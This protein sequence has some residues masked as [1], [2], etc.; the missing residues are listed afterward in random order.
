MLSTT[1]AQICTHRRL[2]LTRR[3]PFT[4]PWML[5]IS[6]TVLL[7]TRESMSPSST[8]TL[9]TPSSRRLGKE[10]PWRLAAR[11]NFQKPM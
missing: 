11:G 4:L 6:R 10:A 8:T 7:A 5:R 9:Q 1:E 3:N 2:R